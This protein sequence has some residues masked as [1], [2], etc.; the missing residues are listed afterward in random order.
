VA[1]K[2]SVNTI[3]LRSEFE[4]LK[5][6]WQKDIENFHSYAILVFFQ[7]NQQQKSVSV[8]SLVLSNADPTRRPRDR[9]S[10]FLETTS[11][12]EEDSVPV[13]IHQPKDGNQSSTS[14]LVSPISVSSRPSSQSI[15]WR[16]NDEGWDYSEF[17]A[18]MN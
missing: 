1:Y 15:E 10:G 8:S 2:N 12:L 11:A 5:L 14:L 18:N 4:H 13:R 3:Y 6:G 9:S 17:S 16:E 7:P